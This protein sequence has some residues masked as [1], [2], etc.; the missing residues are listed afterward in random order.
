MGG[1]KV[2]CSARRFLESLATAHVRFI[3]VVQVRLNLRD[4]NFRDY[5]W[6]EKGLGAVGGFCTCDIPFPVVMS[7]NALALTA[8][9]WLQQSSNRSNHLSQPRQKGILSFG[10]R[11]GKR[12]LQSL[13][14]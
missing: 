9:R 10:K 3:E 2:S 11:G 7:L 14:D 4:Y 13:E 5:N 1:L 6:E 8:S 12:R